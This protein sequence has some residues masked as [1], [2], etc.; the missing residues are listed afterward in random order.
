MDVLQTYL[1]AAEDATVQ[2]LLTTITISL[3][4]AGAFETPAHPFTTPAATAEILA[5]ASPETVARAVTFMDDMF[6]LQGGGPMKVIRSKMDLAEMVIRFWEVLVGRGREP[7]T[8]GEPAKLRSDRRS[9]PK[10]SSR[11]KQTPHR[12]GKGEEKFGK[13]ADMAVRGGKPG[14]DVEGD[15]D[16][17]E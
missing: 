9:F 7:R 6:E 10:R 8:G 4:G 11:E 14:E 12:H 16:V 5:S 15:E 3:E 17:E 1:S 13:S 2:D